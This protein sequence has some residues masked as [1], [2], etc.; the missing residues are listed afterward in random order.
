MAKEHILLE[1]EVTNRSRHELLPDAN[2][3][4]SL[5]SLDIDEVSVF[6][7]SQEGVTF[8]SQKV[9]WERDP[10]E[11]IFHSLEEELDQGC[12]QAGVFWIVDVDGCVPYA[13]H[14]EE[15]DEVSP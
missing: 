13:V 10:R 7:S 5:V 12:I 4:A 2:E 3:F 15:F 9:W 8:I 14:D 6:L 1:D 11:G